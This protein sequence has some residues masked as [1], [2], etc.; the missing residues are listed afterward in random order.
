MSH[1]TPAPDPA[2]TVLDGALQGLRDMLGADGYTL[3][4]SVTGQ[5][6]VQVQILAGE[7]A[8]AECLV[9]LP[10]IEGIMSDALGPTPYTLDRVVLPPQP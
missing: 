10:V 8:C 5:D 6:R 7:D 2:T 9:P 3:A 1:S 4:W